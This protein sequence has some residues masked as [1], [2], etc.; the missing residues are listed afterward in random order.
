VEVFCLGSTHV[1]W[2]SRPTERVPPRVGVCAKLAVAA[3]V[4]SPRLKAETTMDLK[5]D[6]L[7]HVTRDSPKGLLIGLH[8]G[9]AA[10]AA[11]GDLRLGDVRHSIRAGLNLHNNSTDSQEKLNSLLNFLLNHGNKRQYY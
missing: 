5:A 10:S 3:V 2:K 11:L 7:S 4:S 8:G 9:L 6:F 1:G